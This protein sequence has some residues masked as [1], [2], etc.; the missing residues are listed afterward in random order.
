[1]IHPG[2]PWV[3]LAA[4]GP[5]SIYLPKCRSASKGWPINPAGISSACSRIECFG[6]CGTYFAFCWSKLGFDPLCNALEKDSL[7]NKTMYLDTN[8]LIDFLLPT[9]KN[10]LMVRE[11]V[12]LASDLGM[13]LKYTTFTRDELY[14]VIDAKLSFNELDIDKLKDIKDHEAFIHNF[15]SEKED[16]PSLTLADYATRFKESLD[17]TL[18]QNKIFIDT[19][20]YNWVFKRNGFTVTEWGVI[21]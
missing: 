9:E 16:M 17:K 21:L 1:M 11:G 20:P 13:I 18:R 2:E 6:I 3:E 12:R 4:T 10:H 19:T 7:N 14:K 15:L 5:V 8:I